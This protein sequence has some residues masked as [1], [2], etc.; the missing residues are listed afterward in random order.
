MA[1]TTPGEWSQCYL[2]GQE[3]MGVGI[4]DQSEEQSEFDTVYIQIRSKALGNHTA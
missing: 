1:Q 3:N 4:E 2:K